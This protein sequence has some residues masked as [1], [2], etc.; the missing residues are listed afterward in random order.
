MRFPNSL[1][2]VALCDINHCNIQTTVIVVYTP[3]QQQTPVKCLHTVNQLSFVCNQI[4]R[5]CIMLVT[6]NHHD[7]KCPTSVQKTL[8]TLNCEMF[9]THPP[10]QFYN[11]L[12]H[13]FALEEFKCV[14]RGDAIKLCEK[15]V[16]VGKSKIKSPQNIV[17]VQQYPNFY[18]H[19][20]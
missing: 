10:L 5:T 19:T 1:P 20:R 18:L 12:F 15:V 8:M 16:T 9:T 7:K 2:T 14:S 17:G 13:S 4:L 3:Q 6:R 11:E